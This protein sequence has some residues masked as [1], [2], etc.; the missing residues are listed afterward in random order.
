MRRVTLYFTAA[1]LTLVNGVIAR[2]DSHNKGA[3]DPCKQFKIQIVTPSKAID[4]KIIVIPVPKDLDKAMVINPCQPA[5]AIVATPQIIIEPKEKLQ[6][7]QP[8]NTDQL[9]KPPQ[10]EIRNFPKDGAGH[11]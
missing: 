9:F 2:A 6:I 8:K 4:Y 3:D 7:F 11:P 10:F 5:E 1:L